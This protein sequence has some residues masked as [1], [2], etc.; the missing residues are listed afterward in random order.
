MRDPMLG[1]RVVVS[2]LPL[3]LLLA[4]PLAARAQ[5][6]AYPG[7]NP[8]L[9][10]AALAA[11]YA[12]LDRIA[13]RQG[14]AWVVAFTVTQAAPNAEPPNNP[15]APALR[16]RPAEPVARQGIMRI[17]TWREP[18]AFMLNRGP[19][20]DWNAQVSDKIRDYS[21][22][23]D[24]GW[25]Q[26]RLVLNFLQWT[27][28]SSNGQTRVLVLPPGQAAVPGGTP[29]EGFREFIAQVFSVDPANVSVTRPNG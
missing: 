6:P 11:V 27:V 20:T 12:A 8:A 18:D 23:R 28:A 1:R 13:I 19:G 5:G 22:Y 9:Q 26:P 4:P 14:N 25:T 29:D 3:L 16:P 15:F 7:Q 24:G 10:Q 21:F 2:G 17:T